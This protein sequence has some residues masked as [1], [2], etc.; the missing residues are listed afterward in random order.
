MQAKRKEAANIAA[1]KA[2]EGNVEQCGKCDSGS[3]I[4]NSA[5]EARV[6]FSFKPIFSTMSSSLVGSFGCKC[7]VDV[8]VEN[9]SP[10]CRMR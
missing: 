3:L 4:F 7:V 8:S 6:W 1:E 2:E 5:G 9:Q 10:A